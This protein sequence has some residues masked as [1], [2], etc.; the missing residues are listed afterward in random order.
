MVSHPLFL[1]PNRISIIKE[2]ISK[3]KI[4]EVLCIEGISCIGK[5]HVAMMIYLYYQYFKELRVIYVPAF[6]KNNYLDNLFSRIFITFYEDIKHNNELKIILNLFCYIS[7]NFNDIVS[8]YKLFVKNAQKNG[9]KVIS[10]HDQINSNELNSNL[11]F[12]IIDSIGLNTSILFTSSTE[13]NISQLTRK[14]NNFLSRALLKFTEEEQNL[15]ENQILELIK[16]YFS[17]N[18]SDE[19]KIL[20]LRDKTNGSF[21]ILSEFKTFIFFL[22]LLKLNNLKIFATKRIVLTE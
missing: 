22:I 6:N 15:K 13:K 16:L 2:I 8:L 4:T 21:E 1:F 17:F 18:N 7:P 20:I 3:A 19:N 14:D 10:I 11:S 12:Q 5:S 9:K